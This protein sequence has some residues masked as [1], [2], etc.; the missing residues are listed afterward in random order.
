MH[1]DTRTVIV[2]VSMTVISSMANTRICS[3]PV[4][5]V[6]SVSLPQLTGPPAG[7][8]Q[9]NVLL[10][11]PAKLHGPLK[12]R[13]VAKLA[14]SERHLDLSAVELVEL[15]S[16]AVTKAGDIALRMQLAPRLNASSPLAR[17]Q[18]QCQGIETSD[19][20]VDWSAS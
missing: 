18:D 1:L 10:S 20:L 3:C 8:S 14:V 7:S 11:E 13:K 12:L 6:A 17:L 2:K 9:L 5:P 15:G 19:N 4:T 16:Q